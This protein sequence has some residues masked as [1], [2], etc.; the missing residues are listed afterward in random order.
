M[1]CRTQTTC[2][3]SP[4]PRC[5]KSAYRL[6]DAVIPRN[7]RRYV[8][9]LWLDGFAEMT[10][11]ELDLLAAILPLCE[12]ATLAF[13][14]ENEPKA[15]PSWLSIWSSVGKTFPAMP[16]TDRK[17]AGLRNQQL[18]SSSAI[19]TRTV[20]PKIPRWQ[21][22]GEPA[23]RVNADIPPGEIQLPT[24]RLRSDNPHPNC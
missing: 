22:L 11:Q 16:A 14:L 3:I 24:R 21:H 2:S 20:S 1:N 10:P 7:F 18:K 5:G 9:S 12:R 19:R 4:P 23:G 15:D 8:N 17:S 13:C 6:A